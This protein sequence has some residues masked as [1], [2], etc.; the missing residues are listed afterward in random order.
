MKEQLLQTAKPIIFNTEMVKAIL[1]GRKTQTRR[2]VNKEYLGM[3]DIDDNNIYVPNEDGGYI[4]ILRTSWSKYKVGDILWVRETW[5]YG[6]VVGD[7]DD[8]GNEELWLEQLQEHEDNEIVFYKADMD[9]ALNQG[10]SFDEVAWKPSIHMPKKYARIFRVVTKVKI[11]RLQDMNIE[12][13][14]DEGIIDLGF[15]V[16]SPSNGLNEYYE[17][18]KNK[19]QIL[20]N[21]TAK[22][23]YRLEDN[24]FVFVYEFEKV[25]VC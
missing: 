3:A 20:W 13:F 21:S 7:S 14:L 10:V 16:S 22:K 15:V 19:W 5:C 9:E 12:D 8:Y 24:P 1:D 4:N 6:S 25:E 2:V 11:E 18:L 23:G 17:Y